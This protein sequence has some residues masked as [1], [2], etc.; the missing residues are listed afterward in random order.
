M[1]ILIYIYARFILEKY[2]IKE[3][4]CA[5]VVTIIYSNKLPSLGSVLTYF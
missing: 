4:Y 5:V 1:F 3:K 2:I